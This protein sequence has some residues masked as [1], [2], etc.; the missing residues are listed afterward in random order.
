MRAKEGSPDSPTNRTK[1]WTK[2]M[3]TGTFK[4]ILAIVMTL[5][6]FF[7]YVV[8]EPASALAKD[9]REKKQLT[10]NIREIN[11]IWSQDG[12]KY[13]RLVGELTNER[14]EDIKRF[15]REDGAIELISYSSPVHYMKNGEWAAIDNTLKYDEKTGRFVNT[16]NDFIVELG[17]DEP[18]LNVSYKGETLS[19][20]AIELPGITDSELTAIVAEREKKE[21]LTDEEKDDLLRFPEE[22]SS[23]LAYYT[24]DGKEAG[25]EYK[26]SGKSL[27]EYFKEY[28]PTDLT[29]RTPERGRYKER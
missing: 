14:D 15:R 18:V 4:R 20:A 10:E 5:V 21:D 9:A 16:A 1:G 11:S 24:A 25:L 26:L 22:L 6:C 28:Q 13:S 29:R 8:F 27:S 3:S 2:E 7:A 19:I 12:N 17:V 23:A